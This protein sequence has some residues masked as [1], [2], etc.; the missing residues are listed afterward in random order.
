M[1]VINA[2]GN[3]TVLG[4][5]VKV[6]PVQKNSFALLGSDEQKM[7]GVI[8][9]AGISNGFPCEIQSSGT[10][11]VFVNGRCKQGDVIRAL[12][13]GDGGIR[14][15]A[16]ALS[17]YDKAY[18]KVGIALQEGYNSLVSVGLSFEYFSTF[19]EED[20]VAWSNITGTPTTIDDYGI[21]DHQ[22]MGEAPDITEFDATGHQ[23]MEGDARPYRDEL[24]DALSLSSSG[25]GVSVNLAELTQDFASNAAYNA[26]VALADLL[27]KNVQLNHDKD[28]EAEIHPHIHWFQAKDY[29]PNLLF[30]YRWQINGGLKTTA[31]TFLK[32]DNL[33]YP[34]T[35][36]TTIPQLSYSA[37]IP[38]PVGAYLSDIVQ[39]RIY[40][41][42][43]NVSGEFAGVCPYNTGGNA[44]VGVLSFDVH[45]QINSLGSTEE[46]VK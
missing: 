37:P 5:L 36:G 15:T 22:I 45:F 39:F 44:S 41:D 18:L 27:Y 34:Y 23:T 43:G 25:P 7:L 19:A 35:P 20:T 14:G 11:L 28:L 33:A 26:N 30:Q 8:I 24:G 12:L 3:S 46:L 16:R 42:T 13:S 10:A 9:E 31:W 38:V 17:V 2:T 6:N 4:R 21:T 32:C 29:T 1:K 40:R